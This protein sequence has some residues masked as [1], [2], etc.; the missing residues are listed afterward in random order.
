MHTCIY[1]PT[2]PP[3]GKPYDV[4]FSAGNSSDHYM[5]SRGQSATA[6]ITRKGLTCVNLGYVE[7]DNIS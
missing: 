4:R 2:D 1:A 5:N 6:S 7:L 3:P